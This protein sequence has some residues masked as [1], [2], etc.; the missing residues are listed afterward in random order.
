MNKTTNEH[1]IVSINNSRSLILNKYKMRS[2]N[3]DGLPETRI[4]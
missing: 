4:G 3:Y 1:M 2:H